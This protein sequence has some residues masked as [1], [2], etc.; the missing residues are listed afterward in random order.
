MNEQMVR[1]PGVYLCKGCGIG[2]GVSVDA[3]EQLAT[4]DLKIQT[5]RQHDTLCSDEG[6]QVIAKDIADGTVNQAIIGACSSRVMSDRFN[7]NGT[8]VIRANLREQVVWSHP[9]GDE[10]TQMLAAD[11]L[12]M[13]VAQA[14]KTSA[15]GTAAEGDFSRT[16][17][18]VGGGTAGLTAAKEAAATGH[19]VILAERS[20]KLGGWA[21]KFSK[22][23]PHL[24]PYRDP[25]DND[26]DAL[27]AAVE[28]TSAI[29]V[30]TDTI[31]TRTEGSPGKF[32]VTLSKGGTEQVEMIG[33]IVVATGWRPY[34]AT[35]LGHL[36]YGA[37]PDVVTGV[38]L[39]AKLKAGPVGKKAVAFIQC[40]GS[41]DP[42]HLPY[43]SSVCCG[44]S[45]KQALQ[46]VEADPDAMAYIIFDELRTPG[47]AEEFYRQAQEAGV[48]FMKGK[49]SGVDANLCVTYNDELLGDD[50]P[51]E[52]LDMV[53][54]ATGMVP[55][56]TN[57]E[58]D[59]APS[60]AD[61]LLNDINPL[62]PFDRA[63]TASVA[64]GDADAVEVKKAPP[65]GSVA[66]VE[67]VEDTAI[68]APFP[69]G[70]ILNLQYRQGPH[71]PVLADG[72]A[73]SHY[74]CF[75][76]ETR[77][78]GIYTCGPVRRPMDMSESAEDATGAVLKAIQ[79]LNNAS[80][81]QSVHP[82]VGDLSFPKFGLDICTKCRRCTVECPFGAIDEDKNNFPI[83]NPSRCRRCGTCMG[84][85]PVRTINF[86]NYSVQM[87]SDMIGACEIPDEFSGKPRILVL[88][89]ENDAYPALDMAG[90]NRH[91]YSPYMR[92][93]PVRCL[94]SVTTL[95][96]STALEK[97]YDGVMLMGCKSGDDYQC[98]F[99]KGSGIAQERMSKVGETLK[100]LMLEEERVVVEEVSIAD[101]KRV[102]E[103]LTRFSD[104]ITE[105]GFNPFKGF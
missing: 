74:I 41:R 33:A 77:R 17:L 26:I 61:Q 20:D 89:C 58:I 16:I 29:T 25:Q 19:D 37:S 87:V 18:V 21:T 96:I 72:F 73:D 75:P 3:L 84:A 63:I 52:G 51:L 15:P 7:F 4:G 40:A 59:A 104:K 57:I 53:V 78:T 62:S 103:L 11:H 105:I 90:I 42:D 24:P 32:A 71:L 5:C 45:I 14:S 100:S 91:E 31:V 94:G 55:N 1:K 76:Y 23:M 56:S 97:G 70:P 39:E 34:D 13:G 50:I 85:C 36:G 49:V 2:E 48:I 27:I 10:D 79:S 83:L 69:G 47:T 44:V 82:R 92:I 95:W 22:R 64:A 99:V 60:G 30:M 80:E 66:A 81:G 86:D 88:A 102:A 8:Q 35:K 68:E 98:H 101:S 54:L 6:V 38:E 12:R 28:T 46:I 67:A 93:I 43:C 9:A 65:T